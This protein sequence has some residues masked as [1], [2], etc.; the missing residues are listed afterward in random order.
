MKN[1]TRFF[2]IFN[3][4]SSDEQDQAKLA[5]VKFVT[6]Q[7]LWVGAVT[8]NPIMPLKTAEILKLLNVEPTPPHRLSAN[9]VPARPC[10]MATSPLFKKFAV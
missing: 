1:K 10:V 6:Y 3:P 8:L 7:S 2:I 5:Q 4:P 9:N